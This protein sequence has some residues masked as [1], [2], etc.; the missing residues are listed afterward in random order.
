MGWLWPQSALFPQTWQI[1]GFTRYSR[2]E[3][4]RWLPEYHG[5]VRV[6][7]T[8][9]LEPPEQ[10]MLSDLLRRPCPWDKIADGGFVTVYDVVCR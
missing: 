8:T 4:A 6:V 5:K 1:F 7:V 3:I 10:Q 9:N 2:Q